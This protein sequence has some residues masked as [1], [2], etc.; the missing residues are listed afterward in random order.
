MVRFLFAVIVGIFLSFAAQ[1]ETLAPQAFTEA[2][3][4]RLKAA[5]PG[6]TVA[7][8]GDLSIQTK[9]PDGRTLEISL[10]NFYQSY[11]DDPNRLE[12]L[13]R[14]YLAGLPP[15]R[16]A[17]AKSAVLDSKRIIP[18]IKDRPWLDETNGRIRAQTSPNAPGLAADDFNNEL[19]IIYALD[20]PN[21]M[22]YLAEDEVAAIKRSELKTLAIENLIR[23][24]PKVGMGRDG[25]MFIMTAGGDYDASLL[26]LDHIWTS[27][28]IKV[29]G[30]IVVALP[31]RNMLLIT[32]SQ[33]RTGLK[34]VREAIAKFSDGP[35]RL[36]NALFVYRKGRFEKF[37]T[38]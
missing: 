21:R 36:T 32:G 17:S 23:I 14:K 15:R 16:D 12:E 30:D 1:A 34:Q 19:V 8:K 37:T 2:F 26:L 31:Q 38:D 25:D 33:S 35:Y 18:V 29:S 7:I 11:R 20:D 24:L 5:W 10:A 27:G 4:K 3:V 22:R 9:D 28:Q 6:T 13:T